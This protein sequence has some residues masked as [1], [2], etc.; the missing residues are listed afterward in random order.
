MQSPQHTNPAQQSGGY[1][2][3]A[4]PQN[5]PQQQSPQK[6]A[7]APASQGFEDFEDDIPF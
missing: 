1:N 6:A 7:P 4:A 2:Q 3:Q 5:A